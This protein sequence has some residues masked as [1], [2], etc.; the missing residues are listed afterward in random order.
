MSKSRKIKY[1]KVGKID[2]KWEKS[3]KT[4]KKQEGL[5]T[6]AFSPSHFHT[7]HQINHETFGFVSI[8]LTIILT[9]TIFAIPFPNPNY[10]LKPSPSHNPTQLDRNRT[11][12]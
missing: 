5:D 6:L 11:R 10:I 9:P 12:N 2:E 3:R 1:Q 4:A 8:N 7:V